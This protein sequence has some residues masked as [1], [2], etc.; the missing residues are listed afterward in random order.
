MISKKELKS[1]R[2]RAMAFTMAALCA[3][4]PAV[5]ALPVHAQTE[6]KAIISEN[7]EPVKLSNVRAAAAPVAVNEANFPDEVFRRYVSTVCDSNEDG[8]LSEA[9]ADSITKISCTGEYNSSYDG[10]TDFTGITYFKNLETL[11]VSH[12]EITELDI[13]KF[14]KLK[15]LSVYGCQDITALD[16]SHN[17]LLEELSANLTKITDINLRNNSQLTYFSIGCSD[18]N[19]T[20]TKV[21]PSSLDISCNPKLKS[22]TIDYCAGM[23]ELDLTHNP[24]LLYIDVRSGDFSSLDLSNCPKLQRLSLF[25]CEQL[26]DIDFRYCPE[27]ISLRLQTDCIP[28]ADFSKNNKLTELCWYSY[29]YDTFSFP[30]DTLEDLTLRGGNVH[31]IIHHQKIDIS[32]LTNLQDLYL[33]NMGIDELDLSKCAALKSFSFQEVQDLKDLDL[34]ANTNLRSLTFPFST[35][36]ESLNIGNNPDLSIS[37]NHLNE[38]EGYKVKGSVSYGTVL[39]EI[40]YTTFRPG[41][42]TSKMTILEDTAALNNGKLSGYHDGKAIKYEYD[43]GTYKD[44]KLVMPVTA[45]FELD[46]WETT[47]TLKLPDAGYAYTG[48]TLTEP[49]VSLVRADDAQKKVGIDNMGDVSFTFK[50]PNNETVLSNGGVYDVACTVADGEYYEGCTI[51]SQVTVAPATNSWTEEP[52]VSGKTYDGEAV[53][54]DAVSA[55]AAFGDPVITYSDNKDGTFTSDAPTDAGTYYAKITV[56]ESDNW[57]GLTAVKEFTISKAAGT[58][59]IND[60]IGKAYDGA[61]VQIPSDISKTGYGTVLFTWYKQTEDGFTEIN[62]LPKNVGTYKV[63]AQL[64]EGTNHLPAACEK[65]FSISR[66]GN[67]FTGELSIDGWTFGEEANDPGGLTSL[68]G[69]VTYLWSNSKDGPFTAAV[70]TEAGTHY[71]KAHVE[72]TEDY[73]GLDSEPEEFVIE[74]AVPGYTLPADLNGVC[75]EKLSDIELPKGFSWD[76]DSQELGT[77]GEHIFTISYTPED[78]ENYETVTGIEVTVNVAQAVNEWTKELDMKGWTYKEAANRPEAEAKYGKVSFTYSDQ[79]NGV[80]IEKV[81]SQAGTYYV[82]A[83][84]AGTD[85]YTG[86]TAVKRFTIGKA[87]APSVPDIGEIGAESGTKSDD[88]VLPDAW[89]LSDGS[90]DQTLDSEHDKITV[91]YPVDDKNYEYADV[92]GYDSEKHVVIKEITIDIKAKKNRWVKELE[93]EDIDFGKD[94][95]PSTESLYGTPVYQYSADGKTFTDELPKD[96][97]SYY[98]RAVVEGTEDYVGLESAPVSFQIRKEAE[99]TPEIEPEKKPEAKPD[100][101]PEIKPEKKPA[102]VKT[103][104]DA[105]VGKD[106]DT[107][108]TDSTKQADKG[109]ATG[110]GTMAWMFVLGILLS[111]ICGSS[112]LLSIRRRRCNGKAF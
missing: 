63:K 108:D 106:G 26:A 1:N 37:G 59:A 30:H 48:E 24:E 81:P 33:G 51:N 27:L 25:N 88:L 50:G 56:P 36:L 87:S 44:G 61:A 66:A 102:S 64:S 86:L 74:K 2:K 22:L 77:S 11:L 111:A 110:D 65:T 21:G 8:I 7:K 99:N 14:P 13:S 9:E 54:E 38:A 79:E 17:P 19:V 104:T 6:E 112:A 100:K 73:A 55:G 98:V 85:G 60:T 49:E 107:K 101:E 83:A 70:P 20:G 46:K 58:L 96:S 12:Q 16:V 4:M 40:N 35:E 68:F 71:V 75:G 69:T 47:G 57:S 97:G 67:A 3:G 62:E 91:C 31:N 45:R 76:D 10:V 84:V 34:S 95:K 18:S 103:P 90:K 23:T 15:K 32:N 39:P 43:C 72:G 80:F 89:K 94:L 29:N 92:E 52:A 28:S 5:S 41:M 105:P 82:K 109:V 42:D 53:S 78:T 93:M